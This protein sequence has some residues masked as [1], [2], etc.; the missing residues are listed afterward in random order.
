MVY[1]LKILIEIFGSNGCLENICFVFV[2]WDIL[3][4]CC[5]CIDNY[6]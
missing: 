5:N 3:F 2:L 1:Y 6:I 4:V